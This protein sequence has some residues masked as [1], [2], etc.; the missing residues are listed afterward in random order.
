LEFSLLGS[1]LFGGEGKEVRKKM[2]SD[3]PSQGK[4]RMREVDVSSILW[5]LVGAGALET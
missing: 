2:E 1:G 5:D 4:K 3:I